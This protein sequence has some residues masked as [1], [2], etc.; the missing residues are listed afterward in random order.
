MLRLTIY[1]IGDTIEVLSNKLVGKDFP[2]GVV[3]EYHHKSEDGTVEIIRI[4]PYYRKKLGGVLN[5][6][7][8][9]EIR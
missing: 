7:A 6:F 2:S 3:R 9:E 8:E 4:R 5:I 1:R